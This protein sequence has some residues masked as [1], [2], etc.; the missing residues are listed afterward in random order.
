MSNY[1]F[2][3]Y[4]SI[5]VR[6]GNDFTF[7]FGRKIPGYMIY[8]GYKRKWNKAL[9]VV[10]PDPPDDWNNEQVIYALIISVLKPKQRGFDDDNFR[11]GC[12]P[13]PDHLKKRGWL[14]EDT[15]KWFVCSYEQIKW[16]EAAKAGYEKPGTY[17]KIVKPGII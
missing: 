15:G 11:H 17:I 1:Q 6:S 12:K 2:E 5:K 7:A 13:I 14:K 3:A 9:D 4:T 8:G 10:I 16:K